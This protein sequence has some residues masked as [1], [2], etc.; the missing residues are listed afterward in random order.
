MLCIKGFVVGAANIVPGVSGATLAVIFR[1]YDRLI[2]AINSLF[3][4]MKESL[5]FLIPFGLFM[6]IGIIV[7]GTVLDS[8]LDNFRLQTFALIA[9]L[10]AGSLPF[11]H[12]EALSKTLP[13]SPQG[14]EDDSGRGSNISLYIISVIA[15][16][17]IILLALLAPT[18]EPY[19]G[20]DF[21]ISFAV[22][23]FVAGIFSA[24]AMI[25]PG[26]SGAMVLLLFGQ[27][28]LIMHTISLIQ[29]Y[30]LTPFSFELLPPIL[31]VAIPLGLGIVAGILLASRLIA[32][33]LDKFHT[34][35]YFAI[36]GMVFGTIFVMFNDVRDYQNVDDLT[37]LIIVAAVIAFVCGMFISMRFGKT[38]TP[39]N[40]KA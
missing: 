31:M 22:F 16:A 25:I 6:G 30:L 12:S 14:R 3:T 7:T 29:E 15:C 4:D 33:L 19:V 27:F 21:S 38:S 8:V 34:R 9:G 20:A 37:P 13:D 36:L 26:V 10:M 24:A 39:P 11:L 5:K 18:P 28:E 2:E 1:V 35:T 32:W 23:L 40:E 17:F